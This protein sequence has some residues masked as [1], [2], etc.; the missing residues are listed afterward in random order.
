MSSEHLTAG[1]GRPNGPPT[2]ERHPGGGEC[3]KEKRLDGGDVKGGTGAGGCEKVALL[4][5]EACPSPSACQ[6]GDGL[7]TKE[8]FVEVQ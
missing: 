8:A 5:W 1:G 4:E 2:A 7:R 3:V 6:R